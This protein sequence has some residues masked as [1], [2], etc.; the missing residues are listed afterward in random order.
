MLRKGFT[1]IELLVV[2]AIIVILGMLVMGGVQGC[3]QGSATPVDFA[4]KV[5]R[6]YEFRNSNSQT[7]LRVDLQKVGAETLET[8]EVGRAGHYKNYAQEY[9][10]LLEGKSYV[11]HVVQTANP[12]WG[13]LGSIDGAQSISD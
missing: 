7:E 5:V 11:V 8:F 9:A 6:K 3:V 10:N 12:T 2:V 4:A 13:T 1:L